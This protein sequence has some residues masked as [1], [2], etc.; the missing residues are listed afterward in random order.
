MPVRKLWVRIVVAAAAAAAA[1]AF[2]LL[3]LLLLAAPAPA[4][5]EE[6][7]LP[8]GASARLGKPLKLGRRGAVSA[9][10]SPDGKRIAWVTTGAPG[11][12]QR[13]TAT[14]HVWDVAGRKEKARCEFS[15]EEARATTAVTFADRAGKTVLLGTYHEEGGPARSTRF[16]VARVRAWD[17]TTG[18]EVERFAGIR[19]A[20]TGEFN[21]LAVSGDGRTVVTQRVYGVQVWD[22]A[23][24][25]LKAD[26]AVT[27]ED[28]G[29]FYGQALAPG[30]QVLARRLNDEPVRLWDVAKGAKL[31]ELKGAGEPLAL[32]AGGDRLATAAR[33]KVIFWDAGKGKEIG[34]LDGAAVTAAF[35]ADGK[36]V[37][38]SDKDG[39]ARVCEAAAAAGK[40]L[41]K[42]EGA[43]LWLAFAPDGQT[44]ASVRPDGTVL[45]WAVPGRK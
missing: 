32:S 31:H 41:A 21:A 2:L 25:K 10:F 17:A 45:L 7:P 38:W 37:A 30:G 6:A 39:T 44:L 22:A 29:G 27:N 12:R 18:K 1:P 26:F 36:R 15:A 23:T 16:G 14:V 40:E 20:L 11:A 24:G 19:T 5:G 35:S 33:G 4:G 28:E 13:Q 34:R 43:G 3:L 8:K 42:L 9:A